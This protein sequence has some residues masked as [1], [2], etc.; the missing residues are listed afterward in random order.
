MKKVHLFVGTRKGGLIL[1]S[2]ESRSDW[3][4]SDLHFKAW[5][6]MYMGMD[7][8]DGRIHVGASH[9]VFGPSTHY[10]DDFG[11]SWTQAAQSPVFNRPSA[12]GRPPGTVAEAFS[13]DE[14]YKEKP[15]KVVSVW[16]IQPG[17]HAEP[18]VLYA[19]VQP[20][21]LFRSTDSGETWQN[22]EGWFD[23]PHR[24]TL[25][26]GAGGLALHTI[27]PHPDDPKQMWIAVSTG[28]TYYTGDGGKTWSPRNK[29]VRA[30]F[31]PDT[32]P[33][34]GQCV[35]K[36]AVHPGHPDRIY[37]Q[38]HCGMFRSDDG[39]LNWIDI[40]E[41]KLPSRFGFPIAVHPHEPETIYVVPEEADQYRLSID[42]K[43]VVWR[44]RNAGE[45]WEPLTNGLPE[46]AYLVALR[47]AM[48]VDTCADAGIYIGTT[49]GQ[50]FASRDGGDS[51]YLLADFLPPIYSLETV[52]LDE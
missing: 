38:N 8:R 12:S 29:N 26:P 33:E 34:Y 46:K 32:F 28:G 22:C 17:N 35:H 37:Q 48:A 44:S 7:P 49:T 14:S 3:A 2:K 16:N 40:G 1:S 25:F 24:G 47:G 10:S 41:G 50:I 23:H 18:G 45:T 6:V 13:G 51:W 27:I 11:A 4:F 39:G 30:D 5:N 19:G 15:E 20:A 52:V 9:D 43:F 42:G 31:H 36:L 21:A